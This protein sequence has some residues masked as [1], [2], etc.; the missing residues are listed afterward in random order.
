MIPSRY[1]TDELGVNVEYAV[2]F[3][4]QSASGEREFISI[5]KIR[6]AEDQVELVRPQPGLPGADIPITDP[7]PFISWTPVWDNEAMT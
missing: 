7:T 1:I 6:F 5:R 3:T 4:V 2:R